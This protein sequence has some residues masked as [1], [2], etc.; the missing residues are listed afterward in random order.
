ML[1]CCQCTQKVYVQLI[2]QLTAAQ[3]A[4]R[5]QELAVVSSEPILHLPTSSIGRKYCL[6]NA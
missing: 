6:G 1:L 2:M 4:A 5:H 3:Y